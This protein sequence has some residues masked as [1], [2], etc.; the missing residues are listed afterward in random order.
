MGFLALWLPRLWHNRAPGSPS[1]HPYKP[2]AQRLLAEH[3]RSEP[4]VNQTHFSFF[5]LFV[6]MPEIITSKSKLY[7]LENF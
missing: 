3:V 6:N 4:T 7:L 2:Y 5:L 1:F